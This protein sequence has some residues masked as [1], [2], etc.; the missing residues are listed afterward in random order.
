ME[1]ILLKQYLIIAIM[2]FWLS[3]IVGLHMKPLSTLVMSELNF[4][5]NFACSSFFISMFSKLWIIFFKSF[6]IQKTPGPVSIYLI[7]A[8]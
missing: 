3:L 7:I 5:E 2:L 6:N 4:L 1:N 8:A